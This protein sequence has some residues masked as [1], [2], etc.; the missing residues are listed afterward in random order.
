MHT[1]DTQDIMQMVDANCD[2]KDLIADAQ[3]TKDME[4]S[5]QL[6]EEIFVKDESQEEAQNDS[7]NNNKCEEA[8]E[9]QN[10][11]SKMFVRPWEELSFNKNRHGLGYDKRK[12]LSYPRLLQTSSVCECRIS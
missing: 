5:M 8:K 6:M 11:L 12:K 10:D 4:S 9:Q 3:D 2:T 1:C 7:N